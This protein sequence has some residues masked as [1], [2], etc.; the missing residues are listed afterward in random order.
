MNPKKVAMVV[1]FAFL[2]VLFS[3]LGLPSVSATNHSGTIS[4]SET[5]YAADNPHVV[6]GD[7]TV[8]SMATLTIEAGAEVYFDTSTN[9]YVNGELSAIGTSSSH[10]LFTSNEYVKD[11]G[12]WGTIQLN[13]YM[14]MSSSKISYS[15]IKYATTGIK[16]YRGIEISHSYITDNDYGI[17]ADNGMP[18]IEYNTIVNSTYD[19]IEWTRSLPISASGKIYNNNIS[20]NGGK[21][22]YLLQNVA[23][24]ISYNTISS[25]SY[26]IYSVESCLDIIHNTISDNTYTGIYVE[27][28]TDNNVQIRNDNEITGNADGIYALRAKM[29]IWD[30]T[31]SSNT[32]GIFL[33]YAPSDIENNTIMSNTNFGIWAEKSN[34]TIHNN[35]LTDN[36]LRGIRYQ[37]WKVGVSDSTAFFQTVQDIQNNTIT[38]S[39]SATGV[40]IEN[41]NLAIINNTITWF[42]SANQKGI[43][44]WWANGTVQNNSIENNSYGIFTSYGN[45]EIHG[46]NIANNADYG[47][48]NMESTP[49][50]NATYNWWGHASGPFHDTENGSGQGNEVSDLIVF[51]DWLTEPAF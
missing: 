22:V 25:N 14:G 23:P 42:D 3:T 29:L 30:S 26:G 34:Q 40:D 7:V 45:P 36:G 12:D 5:W 1:S 39:V 21:G 10:I 32:Q 46:N 49:D 44:I 31:V 27:D 47:A 19:G 33:D 17:Y 28:Y 4:S 16:D 20:D 8:G 48:Y 50:V 24:P 43:D 35:N 2:S 6:T 51:K 38:S 37:F 18:D 11:P 15:I 13:S 41:A 9:I